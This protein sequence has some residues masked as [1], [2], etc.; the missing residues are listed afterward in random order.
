MS[1]D[2]QAF[3]EAS[4]AERAE[5]RSSVRVLVITGLGLNC[6]VETRIAFERCGASTT[7]VHL[8][9]L[10]EGKVGAQA[11]RLPDFSIIAFV[12]G[13]AFGD[14]LGAGFVFA[15]KIRWRLYDQLLEFIEGG[16]SALG[17]C[18]GF[19]TMVRLGILPGLDGDYRTP[20]TAL[21]PNE[22]LGY[23]NAW[24]TLRF[25]ANSPCIWTRGL[26]RMDLPARHGEGRFLTESEALL[27][28]LER[29][30]L[31]AARYVD[32]AGLPTMAW[33]ANPNGSPGGV[34]GICDPS[35]RL[36]GLMPHPD[37]YLHAYHHPDWPR[38][39]ARGTLVE[40]STGLTI[41]QNGVDHAAAA[42]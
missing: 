2:L 40:G 27:E 21:A 39:A 19:Q 24:V 14:H 32:E 30:G 22:Q 38:R 34:A 26:D 36:F 25:E 3:Q 7:Q 28:R 42:L 11:V 9:D 10:L 37:A 31:V 12:G 29:E 4:R 41:F 15:N 5:R 35:G 6:E 1:V 33:P 17:I 18:N 16:G 23:R 20:R 13:F 8:L